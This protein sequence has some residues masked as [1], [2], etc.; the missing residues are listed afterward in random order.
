M[1]RIICPL[2]IVA[3]TLDI[4][5]RGGARREER[6]ALWLSGASPRTP[7]LVVEAHEP[8]QIA[9]VDYFRLPPQSMRTLMAHL[10]ATRRRIVAQI[11]THPGRA[12]HSE[13]DAEWAIVRHVG[14][15]SLVLPKFAASTTP[16]NFL[17]QAKVYEFSAEGDW[18]LKPGSG[19]KAVMEISS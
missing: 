16:A 12:Y 2:P 5:H 18:V 13:V 19:P 14:A 6:V 8:D 15:I 17:R 1:K 3:Q 4:L 11:H 7:A 9:D 10:A